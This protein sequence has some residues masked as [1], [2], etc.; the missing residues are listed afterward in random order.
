[1]KGIKFL[2]ATTWKCESDPCL[3]PDTVMSEVQSISSNTQDP[4]TKKLEFY[5]HNRNYSNTKLP[6]YRQLSVI[7]GN[8]HNKC[9]LRIA[10]MR[11]LS[12]L[13][14]SPCLPF[15]HML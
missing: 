9:Q 4:D 13:A 11:L 15:F 5:I 10:H 2:Y 14:L 8:Y 3:G 7:T 12:L 1:V 6:V